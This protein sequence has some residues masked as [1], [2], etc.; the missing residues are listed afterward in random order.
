MHMNTTESGSVL[1]RRYDIVAED[2]ARALA[3]L[4][5]PAGA[6]VLD[7]GTGSG[8]CAIYL[9]MRGYRVLTGE[10]A[11]DESFY[12]GRD[13]RSAAK[14]VGVLDRIQFRAFDAR[15]LPFAA[16]EFEAVFFFGVLHHI[17]EADRR[18]VLTEALRVVKAGGAVVFLEPQRQMLE[19]VRRDDPAH[20]PAADPAAYLTG[21]R[22]REQR[23]AGS[24]MDIF[25]YRQGEGD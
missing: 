14:Q 13:W 15:E 4:H 20:P 18:A 11:T 22:I 3:P 2:L 1:G 6:A 12:S 17:A 9:A 5:L 10:P 25:V 8:N 7:V 16:G 23:L 21:K 19:Q 24:W